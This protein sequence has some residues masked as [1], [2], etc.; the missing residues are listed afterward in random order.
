MS[1][2]L[3]SPWSLVRPKPV[4]QRVWDL[5]GAP[6][7]L[8]LLPDHVCER[9]HLTSTRA[10]RIAAVLPELHGRC[11][12]I[13]AGDNLLLRLYRGQNTGAPEAVAVAHSVGLDVVDWGGDCLIVPDCRRLP[14]PDASFDTVSFVA[15][16]N[17]I[18]ERE[19]TL[20]E[21][22]RVVRPGG[23]IVITMIGRLTGTIG[24]AIWWYSEDKHRRVAAGELMG[25]SR[26]DVEN[27][28]QR[29]GWTAIAS[30]RFVYGL[31]RCYLAYKPL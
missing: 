10:E 9:M 2:G 26:R 23:R 29:A 4:W 25:M 18:P 19:E 15:S 20:L 21:A 3:P 16:L 27:L 11:L 6:L 30:R 12:D 1:V 28:L 7:R 8:A 14:F 17:H 24:H 5:V 31:N 13:G 22:F